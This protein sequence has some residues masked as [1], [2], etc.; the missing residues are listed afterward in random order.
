M[1]KIKTAFKVAKV[2]GGVAGGALAAV[3][4]VA[5]A[6]AYNASKLEP[7][8]PQGAPLDA[9][10]Y[11]ADDAAVERFREILRIPT[12]S[13]AD[14]AERDDAAF[15]QMAETLRRL[16]PHVFAA[17]DEP[18]SFDTFGFLMR[19]RG[20]DPARTPVLLMAHHDV[21]PVDGQ[22]WDYPPFEAEIHD[23][24]IWARGALDNKLCLC[25]CMEAFELLASQGWQP[26]RDIWFFSSCGEEVR[27]TAAEE[28]AQWLND[29]GIHPALVL[30]EG[31]AIATEVPLNVSEPVAMVGVS[32]KGYADLTVRAVAPGGHASA[33]SDND[34]T[35]LLVRAVERICANPG[36]PKLIAPVEAMLQELGARSSFAY[37]MV[38]GNM[39]LFRPVVE[40]I[41]AGGEETGA[42]VRSTYAL[43]QLSGSTA[44]NVLPPEATA[45]INMRVAPFETVDEAVARARALA[46]QV[47]REAGMPGCIT[48]EIADGVSQEPA[49]VSPHDDPTFDYVRRCVA[50][51]YPEA[52]CTPY[53][54]SS[55]SDA[56]AMNEASEHVYRM[57]GYIHSKTARELIHAANERIPVADYKRG[58]EFYVAFVSNLDKLDA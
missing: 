48:V 9:G 45:N 55:C 6:C 4:G 11:H 13:R 26:P 56:R 21:V 19:W 16:Y 37:R 23:G 17:F 10:G 49:P 51:V 8:S 50:G 22:D 53:V 33:P 24:Q 39:W 34:A 12:V 29:H 43:T 46:E 54:Q 2:L 15:V 38:F 5:G 44:R 41:L 40:Q 36:A 14:E 35:R 27:G 58:L 30:D 42:M 47:A 18:L 20:S 57:A 32:E 25:G 1:G 7:A 52:G 31:G 28:A 3:A